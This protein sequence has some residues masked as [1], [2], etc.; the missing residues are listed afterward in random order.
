MSAVR[1]RR[2]A[3]AMGFWDLF[4]DLS[5]LGVRQ[6]TGPRS[7]QHNA[8]YYPSVGCAHNSLDLKLRA[9]AHFLVAWPLPTNFSTK[10]PVNSPIEVLLLTYDAYHFIAPS[11]SCNRILV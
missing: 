2:H 9:C 3:I 11:P 7:E 10:D 5:C 1:R 8:T 6:G 4:K